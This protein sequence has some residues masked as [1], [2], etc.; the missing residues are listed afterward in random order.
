MLASFLIWSIDYRSPQVMDNGRTLFSLMRNII[1]KVV[2]ILMQTLAV[3]MAALEGRQ[4]N[5]VVP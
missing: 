2:R 5:K 3:T 1:A 4:K